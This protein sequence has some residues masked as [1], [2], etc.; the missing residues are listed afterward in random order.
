M[1]RL[2]LDEAEAVE[3]RR[4]RRIDRRAVAWQTILAAA[5]TSVVVTAYIFVFRA[6]SSAIQPLLFL[7]IIMSQ[8][9]AGMGERHGLLWR[10][11]R[12]KSWYTVFTVALAVA[13]IGSFFFILLTPDHGP[14][15]FSWVPGAIFLIGF[16]GLGLVQLWKARGSERAVRESREP[17]PLA[18]RITT[19]VLGVFLGAA[20]LSIGIRGD[21]ITSLVMLVLML[22]VVGWLFAWMTDAGPA[23]LGRYWRWPQFGAYGVSMAAIIWLSLRSAYGDEVALPVK[24][25]VGALVALLMIGSALLPEQK[26]V[27]AANEAR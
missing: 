11:P 23:A 27:P 9:S 21:L 16:G 5:V 12:S 25:G 15:W 17:L 13:V 10:T 6:D 22:I 8:I 4:E 19:A 26:H 20:T 24:L 7:L 3:Q 18:T 1:A 14:F 2:Y